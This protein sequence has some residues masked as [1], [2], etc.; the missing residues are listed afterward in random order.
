MESTP[1][2]SPIARHYTTSNE[3]GDGGCLR[4]REENSD[5]RENDEWK[6]K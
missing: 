5:P 4:V 3:D 1:P 2:P 6:N